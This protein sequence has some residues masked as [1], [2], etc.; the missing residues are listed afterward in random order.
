M[1]KEQKSTSTVSHS[2]M[3]L[4]EIYKKAS[5]ILPGLKVNHRSEGK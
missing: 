4:D 1:K 5:A 2:Y 3:E